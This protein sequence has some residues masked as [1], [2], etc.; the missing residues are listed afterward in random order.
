VTRK[1]HDFDQ[2]EEETLQQEEEEE[3]TTL[4][5]ATRAI[6]A[7]FKSQR[8]SFLPHFE[9]LLPK[10]ATYLQS[11][12]KVAR[13]TAIAM[14]DDLIEFT[15]S[16]SWKYSPQ[17]LEPMAAALHDADAD[18]RQGAA[19]G[20][21]VAGQFGGEQFAQVCAMALEPLFAM[22]HERN[23]R[24]EE[25]V[26]ATENAVAAVGKI[27]RYNASMIPVDQVIPAWVDS[28]PIVEDESESVEVYSYLLHLL[29]TAPEMVLGANLEKLPRVAHALLEALASGVITDSAVTAQVVEAVK[30]MERSSPGLLAKLASS[31]G[32]EKMQALRSKGISF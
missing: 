18:I 25:N 12:D 6:H 10:L 9:K 26:L 5:D 15:G 13:V 24:K 3:E 29:Q 28:L 14:F 2:E 23:A 32:P 1:D 16:A 21:G 31:V 30:S 17:F 11:T 22:V 19:Y 20:I 27:C 4:S 7:I 8:E